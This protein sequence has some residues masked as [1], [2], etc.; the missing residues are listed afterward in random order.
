[1]IMMTTIHGKV[2]VIALGF[3]TALQQKMPGSQV[4]AEDSALRWVIRM[5]KG[6][7]S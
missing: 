5:L 3:V 1:M 6:Y 4:A 2:N 7:Q